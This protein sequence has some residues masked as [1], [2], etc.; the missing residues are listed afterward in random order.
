M[1]LAVLMKPKVEA[2]LNSPFS[3]AHRLQILLHTL[4]QDL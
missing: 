3:C 1:V 2:W 4:F